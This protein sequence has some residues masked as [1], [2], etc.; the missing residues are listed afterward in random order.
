MILCD[1]FHVHVPL[2][3]GL[4]FQFITICLPAARSAAVFP[5]INAS[6]T[7]RR[8]CVKWVLL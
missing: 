7:A 3:S 1:R 8:R 5:E 2:L 4:F 6:P